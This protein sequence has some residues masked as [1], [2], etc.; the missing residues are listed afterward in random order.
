VV[1][2]LSNSQTINFRLILSPFFFCPFF[3][4]FGS[5]GP[6]LSKICTKL[7]L[8]KKIYYARKK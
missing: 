3:S 2:T 6:I 7:N 4:W 5:R 8:S 1:S